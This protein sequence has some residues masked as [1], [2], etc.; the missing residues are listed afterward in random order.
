MQTLQVG[1]RR[2]FYVH[3]L[4][5]EGLAPGANASD[6]INIDVSSAFVLQKLTYFASLGDG[7]TVTDS[8][9]VI[10]YVTL[11]LIDTGSS[12]QLFAAPLPI[13][14]IAGT[15]EIPFI[16]PVQ[17]VFNPGSVLSASFKNLSDSETYNIYLALIGARA[18]R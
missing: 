8:T 18:F 12:R 6:S 10:P 1:A 14:L 2:Q 11:Q 13:P 17:Q 5:V 3:D 15:G 9:R 4:S 16:L 7:S